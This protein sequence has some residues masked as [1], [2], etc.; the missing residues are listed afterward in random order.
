MLKT[1]RNVTNKAM[2]IFCLTIWMPVC[3][4][5]SPIFALVWFCDSSCGFS[6]AWHDYLDLL[7]LGGIF[8]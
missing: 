7:F 8:E 3:V 5:V 4:C 2:K 1:I 6:E